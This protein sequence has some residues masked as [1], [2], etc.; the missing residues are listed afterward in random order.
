MKH[1]LF[2]VREVRDFFEFAH[3]HRDWGDLIDRKPWFSEVATKMEE[4]TGHV[5]FDLSHANKK[6]IL[7][8]NWTLGEDIATQLTYAHLQLLLSSRATLL[9]LGGLA[10][11][12][13]EKHCIN[14]QPYILLCMNEMMETSLKLREANLVDN[15][16]IQ[17]LELPDDM[18]KALEELAPDQKF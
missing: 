12:T 18:L 9:G 8:L 15:T 14:A 13:S 3:L 17:D 4:C 6:V 1:R 10:K 5:P 7:L 16:F 2:T 11:N